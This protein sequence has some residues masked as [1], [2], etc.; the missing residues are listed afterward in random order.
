MIKSNSKVFVTRPSL[1]PLNEFIPYLEK[2]WESGMLTNMGPFHDQFEDELKEYLG[3]KHISLVVNGTIALMLALKALDIR[4]EVITTPFSFVAT[5]HVLSWNDIKPVFVDIE[6]EYLN[7]DPERIR[8]AITKDTTAIMPVHVFGN[9]CKT[10]QIET[11]ATENKLSLIYDASHAFGVKLNI[12]SI[13]NYGDL[14][15]L[16][17]HATKAFNTFEGGAII[18]RNIQLK[19][20]IDKLRNYGFINESR[21]EGIGINGKMNEF[22]AALGLVQLKHFNEQITRR[23]NIID[24]YKEGLSEVKGISFIRQQDGL[25][26]NCSF[27]PVLVDPLVYGKSR[28]HLYDQLIKNNIY[29]RRYFYPLISTFP[30]YNK[31]PSSSEKNLP[32]ATKISQQ[33][34]CLPLYPDLS[35]DSVIK[36]IDIVKSISV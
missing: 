15:V 33:I 21:V 27:L 9:P 20:K 34:L 2:I 6:S 13:L 24:I 4:G 22:Q 30:Y 19:N 25:I 7:I 36:I 18:S 1:P 11:I 16:S 14:S 31:L 8:A 26:N 5:S 32:I 10:G 35:H 23:G 12:S 28:D 3:V 17:F 29:P